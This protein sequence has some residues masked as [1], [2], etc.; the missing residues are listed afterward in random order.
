MNGYLLDTH[1]LIWWLAD[2]PQLSAKFRQLL[3]H[4]QDA[5]FW[6]SAASVWEIGI[7]QSVGKLSVSANLI[8]AI[9][10]NNFQM[11]SITAQHAT[12][13]ASLPLHHKDPFDRMLIAQATLE[14]I[15]MLSQDSVFHAYLPFPMLI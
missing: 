12:Y 15:Q 3:E 2:A 6:V 4:E 1:I 13:A 9:Q 11:L 7:K 14:H 5:V 8:E 10:N